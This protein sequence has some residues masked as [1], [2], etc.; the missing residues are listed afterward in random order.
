MFR[1]PCCLKL[2]MPMAGARVV[3]PPL[4]VAVML[5][6]ALSARIESCHER[7]NKNNAKSVE[8]IEC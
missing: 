2:G 7:Q 3:A 1:D 8:N 4:M 6:K 5:T